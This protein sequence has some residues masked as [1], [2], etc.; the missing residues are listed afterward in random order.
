MEAA[1]EEVAVED[2]EE[3]LAMSMGH[4]ETRSAG[5]WSAMRER[6]RTGQEA[7][8]RTANGAG[9]VGAVV[10]SDVRRVARR[11]DLS[12]RRVRSHVGLWW[13][14]IGAHSGS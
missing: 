2:E 14:E 8:K 10:G 1:E 7:M 11:A 3:D 9:D 4:Q 13:T 5:G 6:E 12:E